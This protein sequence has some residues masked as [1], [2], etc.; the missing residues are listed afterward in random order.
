MENVS[1]QAD[2][3]YSKVG[4]LPM[5]YLGIPLGVSLKSMGIWNGILFQRNL[6]V[7]YLV[8][9]GCIYLGGKV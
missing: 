5:A 7:V 1:E 3:L 2:L 9:R 6:N 8:G 4:S